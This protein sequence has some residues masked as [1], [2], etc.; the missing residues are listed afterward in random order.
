MQLDTDQFAVYN[1]DCNAV[2]SAGAGSG[3]TTVLTERYIRLVIDKGLDISE[4]LTLTFTRKATTEMYA[5]IYKRLSELPYPRAADQLLHFDQARIATIDSFCNAIVKGAA[6]RFGISG[7]F[8]VDDREV[9]TSA[10]EAALALV[11]QHRR[12][13]SIRT[14]IASRT[15]KEVV[16]KLFACIGMQVCS[17]V[18][19]GAF[20]V[21]AREQVACLEQELSTAL[22]WT[23][24]L[25]QQILA[26]DDADCTNKASKDIKAAIKSIYPLPS[27]Q[28]G[29][30]ALLQRAQ[31]LVDS[32][33]YRL[34]GITVVKKERLQPLKEA[35][36]QL[37]REAAPALKRLAAMLRFRED[38]LSIGALLDEY[39]ALFLNAKRQKA[40]LSFHDLTELAIEILKNDLNLRQYYKQ[41]IKA[42]MIDEFQDNNKLQKDL[43]YLLAERLDTGT[44]GVQPC[45]ADLEPDKLFFVG[46]EK[47]SI[48]RFRGADVAVFRTLSSELHHARSLATNYRSSPELVAFYNALF[49]GIFGTPVEKYEAAFSAMKP[50]PDKTPN[51]QAVA[52][53]IYRQET[54]VSSAQN[55][56]AEVEEPE[57]EAVA[58]QEAEAL[59]VARRIISGIATQ[60]FELGDVALLFRKTT[61][62]NTYERLFRRI[63]IPFDAAD[64]RGIFAEGPA[65]DFYALLRLAIFPHD[66]SAY[67]TVLRSPFVNLSDTSFFALMLEEPTDPFQDNPPAQCFASD[68]DYERY[69]QGA[70]TFTQL[71][72]SIDKHG[73]APTVASLW[74]KSGYRTA[75]LYDK[76]YR[77]N[78]EHFEYIYRLALDA[79]MRHLNTAAFLDELMPLMGSTDKVDGGQVPEQSDRVRFLTVHKS[80]GLEFKVVILADAGSSGKGERNELPYYR[81]PHYGVTI[82]FKLDTE[83]PDENTENYFYERNKKELYAQ[84]QAELE[85]LFY[86]AATRAQEKLFIF[87]AGA[88]DTGLLEAL[89]GKP[90]QERLA[91]LI[92]TPRRYKTGTKKGTVRVNT[93]LDLVSQGFADTSIPHCTLHF[94]PAYSPSEQEKALR[95]LHDEFGA[96]TGTEEAAVVPIPTWFY[97]LPAREQT[98]QQP[99]KTIHPSKVDSS[100]DA[101]GQE[102]PDFSCE[103]LLQEIADTTVYPRFGSI[104]HEAIAQSLM[105]PETDGSEELRKK[106]RSL[107]G[108]QY[109]LAH[110]LHLLP[111]HAARFAQAAQALAQRFIHSPLGQEVHRSSKF[112]TEFSFLAPLN[113]PNTQEIGAFIEGSMDLIYEYDQ[114]CIIVDF[115]V[116]RRKI[117]NAHRLQ[118]ACYRAAA[119]AFS[120]L[121]VI[122]RLVYLRNMEV[123]SLADDLSAT[124]LYTAL[125]QS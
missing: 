4:V 59:A 44:A 92:S 45:A 18:H 30:T 101:G 1:T 56:D 16:D 48:Y 7:D 114:S 125:I 95:K 103:A 85:R 50:P 122:T 42:I 82:N 60:E 26:V 24:A 84:E 98:E 51:P 108:E 76:Q 106:A 73:I 21:K 49:P 70:A 120:P 65:Q 46:D 55:L 71:K 40:V 35:A 14:L 3:K 32:T 43:L 69:L 123:V 34:S 47:Q 83:K 81:D 63:G 15:F 79:D 39:E 57:E 10:R 38:I 25:C 86:V 54:A 109:F 112:L 89:E 119:S 53:E 100:P 62:Q 13:S 94:F 2:I 124:E 77:H 87:S 111:D 96:L 68:R 58:A 115:K 97:Q 117:K 9:S 61:H 19:A 116:D 80:K 88:H 113:V 36:V 107:F 17:L 118:M 6:Y 11:M 105:H 104:C 64:P 75:L 121:P 74:Y 12:T 22:E 91:A 31:S 41:H 78:S 110:K 93:F 37:K 90:E 52:V 99:I 102:L 66:R 29:A 23:N 27:E 8:R 72:N 28:D 20:A 67:A 33:L 5:R